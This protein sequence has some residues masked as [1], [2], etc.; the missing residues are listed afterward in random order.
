MLKLR[1]KKKKKKNTEKQYKWCHGRQVLVCVWSV[2][3]LK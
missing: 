3:G 2:G 1:G